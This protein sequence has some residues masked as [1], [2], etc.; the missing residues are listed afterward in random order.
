MRV[1]CF[2]FHLSYFSYI[3]TYISFLYYITIPP[4]STRKYFHFLRKTPAE[5][6]PSSSF[7]PT[8]F[9]QP[10]I[11][12]SPPFLLFLVQKDNLFSIRFTHS[13][14][15]FVF[16]LFYLYYFHLLLLLLLLLLFENIFLLQQAHFVL[17]PFFFNRERSCFYFHRSFYFRF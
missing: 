11:S 14:A 15:A 16:S 1:Q 8:Y 12:R 13:S 3:T 17:V 6:R 5:N 7:V 9:Y 2:S 10:S 4:S